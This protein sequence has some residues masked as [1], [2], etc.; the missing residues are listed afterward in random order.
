MDKLNILSIVDKSLL[1]II[2]KVC[3][4]NLPLNIWYFQLII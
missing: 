4:V 1:G 3:L 2:F